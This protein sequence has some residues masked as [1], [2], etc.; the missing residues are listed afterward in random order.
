MQLEDHHCTMA[1]CSQRHQISGEAESQISCDRKR[2]DAFWDNFLCGMGT[3]G[4]TQGG[5]AIPL[6]RVYMDNGYRVGIAADKRA[7]YSP[8]SKKDTVLPVTY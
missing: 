4:N 3:S 1:W 5:R 8:Y 2:K 6:P 7:E